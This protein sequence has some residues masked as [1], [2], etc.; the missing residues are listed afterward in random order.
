MA[1]QYGC[2]LGSGGL[3]TRHRALLRDGVR[4]I[5]D[6]RVVLARRI[7]LGCL[8]DLERERSGRMGDKLSGPS[9]SCYRS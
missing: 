7:V 5:Q 2:W 8:N 1:T 6:E 4:E 9:L 3:E